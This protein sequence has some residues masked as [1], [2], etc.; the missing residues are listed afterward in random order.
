MIGG[1]NLQNVFSGIA[2]VTTIRSSGE[3][4]I[5]SAGAIAIGTT[6]SSGGAEVVE[7]GGITS[8]TRV[9]SGGV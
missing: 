4:H 5:W 9:S 8:N 3:Q 2:S 1:Q 6:I 7:S